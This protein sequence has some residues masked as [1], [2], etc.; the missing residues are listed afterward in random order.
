M[1][2]K[3]L[4]IH[5]QEKSLEWLKAKYSQQEAIKI[6]EA[7]DFA[8]KAHEGQFRKSGEPYITH[9]LAVACIIADIGLDATSIR[10]GLL[11]DVVED[12][13]ITIE[14]IEKIFGSDVALMVDGVTKLS[15]LECRSKV[16]R[17]VESF[18]K[19]F[20]ATAKDIRVLIIKLA[21]RLHNMRTLQ[22]HTPDKQKEIAR[23]TIEIYAPLAHRLGIFNLKNELEDLSLMYLDPE[24]Y[25]Y[26]KKILVQSAVGAGKVY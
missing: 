19:M 2:I 26:I 23:E 14:D 6:Q 5:N 21:D 20:L 22:A 18:R 8:A 24:Q 13:D 25:I 1:V 3:E 4:Y 9:C 15:K 17:Q 11:H 16:E 10:A 12:T 7:Y